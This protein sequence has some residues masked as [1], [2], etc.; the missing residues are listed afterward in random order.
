[1]NPL[2]TIYRDKYGALWRCVVS[3]ARNKGGRYLLLK[4]CNDDQERV[5]SFRPDLDGLTPVPKCEL[6]YHEHIQQAT[7]ARQ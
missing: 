2:R 5:G 3:D 7:G 1:M 4:M 6:V